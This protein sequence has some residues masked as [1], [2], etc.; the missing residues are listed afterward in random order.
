[1]FA[2]QRSTLGRRDLL[3][4]RVRD[5]LQIAVR[6]VRR[7]N[8]PELREATR[9]LEAD[10]RIV[11]PEQELL[12][13]TERGGPSARVA[14]GIGHLDDLQKLGGLLN[15]QVRVGVGLSVRWS[16]HEQRDPQRERARPSRGGLQQPR[17]NHKAGSNEDGCTGVTPTNS[18]VNSGM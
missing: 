4:R 1:M 3:Q 16:R 5:I 14:R 17:V 6:R 13:A 12:V 7:C 2:P 9:H 11:H 15:A 8:A 18:S 10:V